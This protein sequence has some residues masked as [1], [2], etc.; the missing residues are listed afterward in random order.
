MRYNIPWLS[1]PATEF[2][3]PWLLSTEALHIAH[4]ASVI[5]GNRINNRSMENIKAKFFTGQR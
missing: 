1:P 3:C 2:F 4:W 5:S